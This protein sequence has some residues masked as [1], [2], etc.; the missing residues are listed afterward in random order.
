MGA[1]VSNLHN[2]V[3]AAESGFLSIESELLKHGGPSH[4]P[5]A[6]IASAGA[7]SQARWGGSSSWIGG[8]EGTQGVKAV[9][10]GLQGLMGHCPTNLG[11]PSMCHHLPSCNQLKG[12]NCRP[13]FSFLV[14]VLALLELGEEDG[15]KTR[16]SW[17]CPSLALAPPTVDLS[18]FHNTSPN[19]PPLEE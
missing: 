11:L 10:P 7:R 4:L 1:V 18:A 15:D 6:V 2:L 5:A 19:G 12:W 17:L 9:E 13:A 3:L 8:E 14:S 16:M